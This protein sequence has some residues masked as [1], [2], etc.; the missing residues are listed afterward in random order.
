M[1]RERGTLMPKHL[2]R[3]F[4]DRDLIGI[5]D[6]RRVPLSGVSWPICNFETPARHWCEQDRWLFQAFY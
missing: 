2:P 1:N 6:M 5:F 4:Q 3:L